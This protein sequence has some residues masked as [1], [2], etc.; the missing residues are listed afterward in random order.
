MRAAELPATMCFSI[1]RHVVVGCLSMPPPILVNADKDTL[2]SASRRLGV[3]VCRL[4]RQWP[5]SVTTDAMADTCYPLVVDALCGVRQKQPASSLPPI[6]R[7]LYAA[8]ADRR[9]RQGAAALGVADLR[10][11]DQPRSRSTQH[12]VSGPCL[13]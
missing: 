5:V 1:G 9:T 3:T 10:T 4:A 11:G 8:L 2:F 7:R 12:R 13:E 6:H